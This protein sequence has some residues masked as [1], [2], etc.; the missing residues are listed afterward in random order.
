MDDEPKEILRRIRYNTAATKTRLAIIMVILL[1]MT[2]HLIGI[3]VQPTGWPPPARLLPPP[4][5]DDGEWKE[6]PRSNPI[7]PPP[8]D[9]DIITEKY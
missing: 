5:A 7:K 4:L 8:E 3:F 6:R 9:S 1:V 2:I